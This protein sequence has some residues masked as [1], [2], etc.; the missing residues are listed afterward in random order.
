M[1]QRS[2]S[3]LLQCLFFFLSFSS[4]STTRSS[5]KFVA[6]RAVCGNINWDDTEWLLFV[7]I[8]LLGPLFYIMDCKAKIPLQK[9][10][11]ERVEFHGDYLMLWCMDVGI[12]LAQIAENNSNRTCRNDYHSSCFVWK[13]TIFCHSTHT[14]RRYTNLY[15]CYS[16]W[17]NRSALSLFLSSQQQHSTLS[18][19]RN[20]RQL[21]NCSPV[22]KLHLS[23]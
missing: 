17:L 21:I 5:W 13:I 22:P 3:A 20:Q 9:K 12:L 14:T 4:S 2:H 15:W 1:E 10:I 16:P 11:S 19:H 6:A 18:I 7:G 8:E 23:H